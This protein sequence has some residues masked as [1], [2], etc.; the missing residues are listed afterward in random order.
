MTWTLYGV[1]VFYS[2]RAPLCMRNKPPKTST[3][4]R[5]EQWVDPV[6][7]PLEEDIDFN[8]G[9]SGRT[10]NSLQLQPTIP[11]RMGED[12]LLMARSLGH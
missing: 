7:I 3:K 9:P 12:W 8:A 1:W 11:L 4:W 6:K 10:S 2:W 5:G